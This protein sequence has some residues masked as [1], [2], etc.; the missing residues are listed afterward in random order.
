MT[1]EQ[2]RQA[3]MQFVDDFNRRDL[4]AVAALLA[5]G[6]VAHW[7]G[8]PDVHGA[9]AWLAAVAPLL[10]AMPDFRYHIDAVSAEGELVAMRYHWTGTQTGEMRGIPATGK[11]LQ[12][13]GMVF[14]QLRDGKLVEEWA[15]DDTMGLMQQLGVLPALGRQA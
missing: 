8:R 9:Q 10:S 11:R 4:D 12:V 5:P 3:A 15:V 7:V 13:E 14:F 2:N 6:F 1:A